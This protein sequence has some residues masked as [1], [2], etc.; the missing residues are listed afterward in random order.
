MIVQSP[1]THSSALSLLTDDKLRGYSAAPILTWD[2]WLYTLTATRDHFMQLVQDR[3]TYNIWEPQPSTSESP[4]VVGSSIYENYRRMLAA[5]DLS[6]IVNYLRNIQLHFTGCHKFQGSASHTLLK[7]LINH[8]FV[9]KNNDRE[10]AEATKTCLFYKGERVVNQSG[11]TG[12]VAENTPESYATVRILYDDSPDIVVYIGKG[13]LSLIGD[14]RKPKED[15]DIVPEA[16]DIVRVAGWGD[17]EC[18]LVGVAANGLYKV[19]T[20]P[21]DKNQKPYRMMIG[22]SKVTYVRTPVSSQIMKDLENM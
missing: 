10:K 5:R 17:Q 4:T 8:Y 6:G 2:S 12:V 20:I 16:G 14:S 7:H 13:Y 18:S 21:E 9:L 22:G 19:Q 3:G 11:R 1:V 15:V